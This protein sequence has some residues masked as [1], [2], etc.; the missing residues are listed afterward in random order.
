MSDVIDVQVND[1]ADAIL[2]AQQIVRHESR[3]RAEIRYLKVLVEAIVN[4]VQYE[5]TDTDRN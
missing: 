4:G 2:W 5:D 1:L 3:G